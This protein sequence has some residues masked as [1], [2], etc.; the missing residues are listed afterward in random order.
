M[1]LRNTNLS[2]NVITVST[3]AAVGLHR[4]CSEVRLGYSQMVEPN[5]VEHTSPDKLISRQNV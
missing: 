2:E 4:F 5:A 1:Y 3:C